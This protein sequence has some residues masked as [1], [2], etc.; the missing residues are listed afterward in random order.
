MQHSLSMNFSG[1]HAYVLGASSD[2]GM[3]VA[4]LLD[5]AGISLTL[6]AASNKGL[7]RIA[8]A[9]PK[10]TILELNLEKIAAAATIESGAE[11]VSPFEGLIPPDYLVDCMQSD[12]ESFI[13]SAEPADAARYLSTNISARAVC[14]REASRM[15]LAKRFGRCVFVSSTAAQLP[16]AGQG[17]YAAAKQAGEALYKSLGTELGRRGV[18]TC[19]L[20]LGY[21]ESGRG[22]KFLAEN[23]QTLK[24]IPTRRAVTAKEAAQTISF[25]LS[26]GAA[27][28]N[29]TTLTMD[30]GLTACK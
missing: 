21:V 9:F 10:A 6:S 29:A 25:L 3:A 20:R 7:T 23:P 14:L 22:T 5:E 18:T 16:N 13:A 11:L 19:S 2:L 1:D 12:F 8:S 27:M 30:G 4:T 15:M 26:N 28:I 24:R 17:Y